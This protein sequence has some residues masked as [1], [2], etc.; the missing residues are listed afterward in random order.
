MDLSIIIVNYNT[1]ELLEQCLA[2]IF[3]NISYLNYEVFVVDNNSHDKSQNMVKELFPKV[4]LIENNNNYGFAKANNQAIK[5]CKGKYILLLNSDTIILNNSINKLF[6]FME[7]NNNVGVVGPK[8]LYSNKN[9]QISC[10]KYS[11][12]TNAV[13]PL[14]P[15]LNRININKLSDKYFDSNFYNLTQKVDYVC[16]ACM[17]LKSH[18][19]KDIGLFDEQFFI[20]S[21]E[22]DLCYRIMKKGWDI[23]YFPFAEVIHFESESFNNSIEKIC[24]LYKSKYLFIKKHKGIFYGSIFKYLTIFIL[25]IRILFYIGVYLFFKNKRIRSSNIIKNSLSITKSFFNRIKYDP[26]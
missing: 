9:L 20:Y 17:M 1:K 2:S 22:E 5:L 14:I 12:I 11:T 16:G 26:T 6:E 18:L 7:R 23:I 4:N 21:E 15:I 25:I 24:F 13:Y 8:L 19:F 10:R 3:K